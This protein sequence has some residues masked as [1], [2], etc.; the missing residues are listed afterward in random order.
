MKLTPATVV[1]AWA[2]LNVAL[3]LI[4]L[5]FGEGAVAEILYPASALIIFGFAAAVLLA[6]HGRPP[7]QQVVRVPGG[8][9][10]VVWFA[11]GAAL[12]GYGA[13]FAGWLIAV[14]VVLMAGA[15]IGLLRS[16]LPPRAPDTEQLAA[17]PRLD[18]ASPAVAAATA[19][20]TVTTDRREAA[21]PHEPTGAGQPGGPD[22][23]QPAQS[24][25]E[26]AAS[27]E[28]RR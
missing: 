10:Y 18:G 5:G 28:E 8:I 16:P 20:Q 6:G 15:V 4:L 25:V 27:T 23:A 2:L 7:P 14:G 17:L 19:E 13:I 22:G 21:E 12:C 26:Q 3:I 1:V 9:R 24:G 11:V